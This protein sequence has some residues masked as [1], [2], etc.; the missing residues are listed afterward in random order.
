MTTDRLLNEIDDDLRRAPGQRVVYLEGKTDT[1]AVF[2]LL[3]APR[4][5]TGVHQGVLVR[6]LDDEGRR[7]R[8]PGSGSD[9]VRRRVALAAETGRAHV[10]GVLDGDGRTMAMLAAEFGEPQRG[11]LFVWEGYCIENLLAQVTWPSGWGAP[12]VLGSYAAYVALNRL[13]AV[14]RGRLETLRLHKFQNPQ[15]GESLL[16]S[17]EVRRALEADRHLI[18][19]IDV[20]GRFS[21]E[22]EA[23]EREVDASAAR[24][25]M[26]LNGKWLLNH[27]AVSRSG[28][29]K[30]RCW[31]EWCEA[32]RAAGGSAAVQAWWSRLVSF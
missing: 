23:Y 2:A 19:G 12:P 28:S 16:D 11:P 18:E 32:V 14:L 5:R 29:A 17:A 20:A 4:S 13:H 3:G 15:V 1:D 31:E 30:E 25:H 27:L 9:A 24:G 6:G 8:A 21:A 7:G 10:Y 22:V 26:L